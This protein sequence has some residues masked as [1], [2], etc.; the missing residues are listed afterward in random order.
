MIKFLA[1]AKGSKIEIIIYFSPVLYLL[2]INN[3]VYQLFTISLE[4]VII[5]NNIKVSLQFQDELFLH[6]LCGWLPSG[7]QVSQGSE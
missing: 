1:H 3:V 4:K 2:I 7:P 6:V 5:L